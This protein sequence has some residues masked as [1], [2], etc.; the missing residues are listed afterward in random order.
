MRKTNEGK[1]VRKADGKKCYVNS[2]AYSN[3]LTSSNFRNISVE[4]YEENINGK[5]IFRRQIAE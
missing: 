1:V 5:R 2:S 3:I 4:N